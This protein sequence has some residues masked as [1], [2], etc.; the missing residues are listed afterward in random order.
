LQTADGFQGARSPSSRAK[1][2]AAATRTLLGHLTAVLTAW[3]AEPVPRLLSLAALPAWPLPYCCLS[4]AL[5]PPV[6][7]EQTGL[8]WI[9]HLNG[10]FTQFPCLSCPISN[11]E[12]PRSATAWPAGSG[13]GSASPS[14]PSPSPGAGGTVEVPKELEGR[15]PS[16]E[17]GASRRWMQPYGRGLPHFPESQGGQC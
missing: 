3:G 12:T 5:G 14:F 15:S 1:L 17:E 4:T 11:L 9:C 16:R 8:W 10:S 13:G 2:L 6:P 7:G